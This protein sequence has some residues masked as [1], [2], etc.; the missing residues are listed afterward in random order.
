MATYAYVLLN[1]EGKEQKGTL[2][3]ADMGQASAQLKKDG[4]TLISLNEAG[5][6][7]KD[8]QLSF[9]E[10]KPKPRDMAVF[11]RQ[12]TSILSAGV[13]VASALDMMSEQTDNKML[14]V[15]AAGCR[16]AIQSGSSLAD[17]MRDYPKVFPELFITMVAAGEASGSLEV[18]FARMGEQFEK[19]EKLRSTVKKASI[20]PIVVCVVAV[21]VV[22]LLLTFVIPTFEDMLMDLGVDLPVITKMVIGASR[23]MQKWWYLVLAVIAGL[24]FYLKHFRKT[25]AGQRA[26]GR[27]GL[28]LPLFGKLTVKTAAARMCRTMST[29]LAAGI[30]LIDVIEI[31]ANTMSNYYFKEALLEAKDDVAMGEPLSKILAQNKLFPPTVYHMMNIGEETGRLEEMLNKLAQ[32]YD[33]EVE[34]TTAQVMAALEPMII[35]VLAIIIGTIVLAVIMPMGAMYQGLDNL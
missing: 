12:I 32:Y 9:M 15:A 30:P 2:E 18:A 10:K 31:T 22:M 26:F 35:I 25:E 7:A 16:T 6:L 33:E 17:A 21:A 3:A 20:Y 27:I 1:N 14:S 19:E 34:A 11:C 8:V 5:L 23:F 24:V 29:L 28:K 13:P 4:A